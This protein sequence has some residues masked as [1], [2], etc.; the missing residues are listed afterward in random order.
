MDR[1]AFA[2]GA[3]TPLVAAIGEVERATGVPPVVV[4]GIAVLCRARSAERATA[5][6]D[7]ASGAREAGATVLET[8]LARAD[9]TAAG[10]AGV[11]LDTEFGRARVDVIE[12]VSAKLARDSEVPDD[13]L[14]AMSHLW[15][16]ETSSPVEITVMDRGT[17]MLRVEARVAQ[18][19]PLVAMKLQSVQNR[20]SAKEGTDLLDIVRLTLDPDA[21]ERVR[22]QLRA[23][24]P[25][26]ASDCAE[27]VN[28]VLLGNP[29]LMARKVQRAG[30]T[31]VT[32]EVIE[33]V[34][35]IL[36]DACG[37]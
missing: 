20:G 13:R 34:A 15:A 21:G 14:Y 12:V 33:D 2:H 29:A 6:L 9:A 18:P 4:G 26:I 8:L 11:E 10:P 1:V 30:G 35:A 22:A 37:R 25:I 32:S 23:V 27:F 3:M 24:D 17:E 7:T 5:D 36:L 31:D 28:R 19:G 16:I